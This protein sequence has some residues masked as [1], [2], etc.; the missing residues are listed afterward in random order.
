VFSSNS[1]SVAAA[2]DNDET[3]VWRLAVS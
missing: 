2:C 1:Q 3:Y